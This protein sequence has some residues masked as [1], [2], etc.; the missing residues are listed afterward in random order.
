[1]YFDECDEEENAIIC[2]FSQ[3]K[4]AKRKQNPNE[5][6]PVSLGDELTKPSNVVA[7]FLKYFRSFK[8]R[9]IKTRRF[10]FYLYFFF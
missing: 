10:N 8:E 3:W 1:M 2:R 5:K 6:I 9:L 7:L 4:S